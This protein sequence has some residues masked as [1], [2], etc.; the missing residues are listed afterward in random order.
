MF[1]VVKYRREGGFE[2]RNDQ[3]P[4]ISPDL[5]RGKPL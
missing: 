4:R 3:A 1:Q 5:G 2:S